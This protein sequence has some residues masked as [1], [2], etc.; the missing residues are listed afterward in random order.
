LPP[1]FAQTI[2]AAWADAA[3]KHPLAVVQV[4]EIPRPPGAKLQTFT[5]DFMPELKRDDG[6]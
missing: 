3:G 4:R 5:S 6:A 1:A 2:H